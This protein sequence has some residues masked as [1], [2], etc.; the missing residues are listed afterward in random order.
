MLKYLRS[1]NVRREYNKKKTR[2][3]ALFLAELHKILR[4]VHHKILTQLIFWLAVSCVDARNPILFSTGI[5][6]NKKHQTNR[7]AVIIVFRITKH[8]EQKN[9]RSSWLAKRCFRFNIA[10]LIFFALRLVQN[11]HNYS[12]YC[13]SLDS[14]LQEHQ[15]QKPQHNVGS[16]K[17]PQT[18]FTNSTNAVI[19]NPRWSWN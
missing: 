10:K 9:K 11:T 4:S 3:A 19:E 17:R 6:Q 5:S 7:S 18:I 13:F 12:V 15:T 8:L 16:N 14:N 1:Q 2:K